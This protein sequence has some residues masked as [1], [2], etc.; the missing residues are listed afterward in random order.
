MIVCRQLC[1]LNV[2]NMFRY[3][4]ERGSNVTFAFDFG[5]GVKQVVT[6]AYDRFFHN[7]FGQVTHRYTKGGCGLC[8]MS[9]STAATHG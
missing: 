9:H 1:D 6:S 3:R 8:L 7:L 5:D 2:M 4:A